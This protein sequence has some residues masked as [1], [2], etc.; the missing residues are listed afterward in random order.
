VLVIESIEHRVAGPDSEAPASIRRII[1]AP[2]PEVTLPEMDARRARGAVYGPVRSR[3]LGNSLGLNLLPRG[4]KRCPFNCV[5][6]EVGAGAPV[7]DSS[8]AHDYPRPEVIF[9]ALE[10]ALQCSAGLEAITFSGSGEPTLHPHF[11]ELVAGVAGLRDRYCPTVK[12]VVLSNAALADRPEVRA[13]L[14]LADVRLMKLDAGDPVTYQAINRPSEAAT[15]ERIVH[16]LSRVGPIT[17]QT[18]LLGGVVSNVSPTAR[19]AYIKVIRALQPAAIQLYR[20]AR[21]TPVTDLH[22]VEAKVVDSL[23]AEIEAETG[24]PAHSY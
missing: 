21:G 24:I 3:R 16:N 18:M 11:H 2:L 14:A 5:Y 8:Q 1:D 9:A 6:C 13:G 15:F 10:A 20:I 12:V 22:I 23:A 7:M 19:A 4:V 17:L